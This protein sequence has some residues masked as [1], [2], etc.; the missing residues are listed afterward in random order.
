MASVHQ[1]RVSID[2]EIARTRAYSAKEIPEGIA[3]AICARMGRAESLRSI[4][5]DPT[6]PSRPTVVE[7]I[8]NDVQGFAAQYTRARDVGLDQMADETLEIADTPAE[9]SVE[10]VSDKNGKKTTKSDAWNHRR[11]QIETRKWYLSKLAPKKYGDKI[12][13][14]VHGE[15]TVVEALLRARRRT[16]QGGDNGE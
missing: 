11:L 15:L 12:E 4:C 8:I 7:W 2:P 10:E 3:E 6:M 9:A 13:H 16:G 14:E 5:R 1:P